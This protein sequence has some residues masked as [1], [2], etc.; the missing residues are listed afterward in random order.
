MEAS[1]F[2]VGAAPQLRHFSTTPG[3]RMGAA[4]V[5]TRGNWAGSGE[6]ASQAHLRGSRGSIGSIGRHHV[7]APL[8]PSQVLFTV[9]AG[10]EDGPSGVHC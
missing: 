1:T 4:E 3:V 10:E 7:G 5:G 9:S 8:L 2:W 6:G